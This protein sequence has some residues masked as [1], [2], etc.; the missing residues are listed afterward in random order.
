MKLKAEET[1]QLAIGTLLSYLDEL[2]NVKDGPDTEF[3]YGEKTAFVECLE[4][5]QLWEES[6]D[7]GLNFVI[8]DKYP[9]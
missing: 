8:E 5:L 7:N 2:W 4:M 3:L 9:L 1:L 6:E